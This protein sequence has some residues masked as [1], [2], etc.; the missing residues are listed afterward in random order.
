MPNVTVSRSDRWPIGTT[1]GAY[2]A[3][4]RQFGTKPSGTALEE[5]AVDATGKLT[6]TTLSEDVPYVLYAGV[7]EEGVTKHRYL[8]LLFEKPSLFASLRERIS[9]RRTLAGA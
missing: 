4:A 3:G 9:R 5:H 8:G 2:P 1:V 6:F 7:T